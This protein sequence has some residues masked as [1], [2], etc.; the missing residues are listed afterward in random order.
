MNQILYSGGKKEKNN[1]TKIVKAFC[2]I[3]IVFSLF[4]IVQ[5]TYALVTKDSKTK[6]GAKSD[7]TPNV[8]V[9]SQGGKAI[10]D[11][12]HSKGISKVEYSWNDGEKT[13]IDENN[14]T[15]IKEELVVPNGDCVLNITIVD[16]DGIETKCEKKFEYDPS[17]DVT[18]PEINIKAVPGKITI[19]AKDNVEMSYITYKWNDEQ[20]NKVE[21]SGDDK[22][23]ITQEIEVK[24]GRNTLTIVAVD[25]NGN[26]KKEEK[27]ILG[28]SKPK[29]SVGKSGGKLVIKVTDDDEVTKVEYNLN[30]TDYTK[31]NTNENKKEFEIR[32]ALQQGENKITI[33][34]YN[35]SGLVQEFSG[36]CNY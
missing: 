36:K 10:L 19:E 12:S 4:F 26:S 3:I 17:T 13:S 21:V 25:K 35:K 11:I 30:G 7:S 2:I 20:E 14:K 29:I 8:N 16:S 34:A 15:Q 9:T 23:K 27:D 28:A 5:G 18:L 32:Q 6:I 24:K 33:K 1:I 31:E 22:T